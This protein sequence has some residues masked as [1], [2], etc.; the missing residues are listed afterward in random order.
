[1]RFGTDI[2]VPKHEELANVPRLADRENNFNHDSVLQMRFGQGSQRPALT[3][4]DSV[5]TMVVTH[6]G[7]SAIL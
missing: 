2:A 5:S 4:V 1:M 3:G 6:F 7:Q